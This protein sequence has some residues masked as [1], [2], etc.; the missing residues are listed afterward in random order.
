LGVLY[1][2]AAYLPID[3]G[4]PPARR[5]SLLER[6]GASLAL[7]QPWVELDGLAEVQRL[8]IDCDL[9]AD[10][11]APALEFVQ[12]PADLAY[13]IY[14]SG[15]TGE[16]KGVMLDHRGPVNYLLDINAH[17]DVRSTDRA[18][19]LSSLSF[20]LS[21]YD[22][23]GM[24]AAG[25]AVVLPEAG[26]ARDPAF[27]AQYL[28][29]GVTVWNSVPA[30]LGLLVD[31]AEKRPGV[32]EAMGSVQK[33]MLS[34]DW[35][36]V[37]LP[38]AFRS[39]VSNSTVISVGGATETS[40]NAV[41][42][43]IG[44][45]EPDWPSIP[46]GKP[47][48]NQTAW[49]LSPSLEPCPTYVAGEIH[50]GGVGLAQG[51]W[52]DEEQ[53][54]QRF[55]L[56]PR[57]GERLYRTGDWGR[58]LPSG[59]IEFLGRRDQQVKVHGYRVELGE[60]EAAL[61]RNAD[62][63]QAV[64]VA[65]GEREKRLVAHVVLGASEEGF[66]AEPGRAQ[67]RELA[68]VRDPAAR[69][70]LVE[71]MLSTPPARQ[72]EDVPV[73]VLPKEQAAPI[74]T[75][76]KHRVADAAFDVA[77]L[78]RML[79]PLR[80]V[81]NDY[82]PLPKARYASPGSLYSVQVLVCVTPD[83]ID[84]LAG[85]VY[86]H[87][88]IEHALVRVSDGMALVPERASGQEDLLK[89]SAFT[90][91]LIGHLAAIAPLYGRLSEPFC[92]LEA[93][94]MSHLLERAATEE[95]V[96]LQSLVGLQLDGLAPVLGLAPGDVCLHALVGGTERA[97]RGEGWSVVLAAAERTQPGADLSEFVPLQSAVERMQFKVDHRSIRHIAAP[98]IALP[99]G[100]SDEELEQQ[101]VSRR[102]FR[103]YLP[104]AV[105][106]QSLAGLLD[107][108][109]RMHKGSRNGAAVSGQLYP[110]HLY[111]SV[112]AGRV[113]GLESGAYRYDPVTHALIQVGGPVSIET[114]RVPPANREM[115]EAAA[116]VLLVV[117]QM[118]RIA[119]LCGSQSELVCRLEAGRLCQSLEDEASIHGLGLCQASFNFRGLEAAFDLS[120]SEMYVHAL[121][122]G[123][124]DWS[125]KQRGWP[126][127]AEAL[128]APSH[129]TDAGALRAYCEKVLP[130]YMVPVQIQI[131]ESLPLNANGKVD[132]AALSKQAWHVPATASTPAAPLGGKSTQSIIELTEIVSR[133]AAETFAV[134]E[135]PIETPFVNLGADSLLA[136]RFRN[137]LGR[138]L[139]RSLPAT[140]VY[141]YPS[142]QAIV[143]ALAPPIEVA[144]PPIR[145]DVTEPIAIVGMSCRAPGGVVDL[146]SYWALLKE[147]R[148][149]IGPFPERWDVNALFDPDPEAAGKS[150]TREGG[151]LQDVDQ[152]DA[153]FF[154][155]SPREAIAMD[156]QQRLVLEVVW[157]ALE[158]AGLRPDA[159][160]ESMT[161]VYL[162]SMGSDYGQLNASLEAMDGHVATGQASSVL[163]GRVSYVLG[164][165]GP[166]MT[167]DTACSSSLV[168]L[169][170][171]CSGLRQGECDLA[172]AGG[173]QV[174]STPSFFVEF[175]RLRGL[176]PD[177]RCKSF[178]A[179]ADGVGWSEGC[180]VLVLKRLSDAKRDGDRVLAVLRGS[181]VNQDGRS[182]GLT[183]PNGPS[184]QRVIRRALSV[185]GLAAS[186]ID[187]VEAHGTGT[188]LGDPIEA[189][190]LAAVFG[191]TRQK[192]KPL[193]IGSSKSNLGHTSAAAGV[194]G[195]M[196]MVLAL[197]HERLPK[198]LHAE[199]PSAHIAWEGSGLSLLQEPRLWPRRAERPRIFGVSA[200]GVS[201]TNAHVVVEEAPVEA[202]IA[203]APAADAAEAAAAASSLPPL[204]AWPVLLSARS[205]AALK[206]QAERLREHV[207]AHPDL[208]LVD[209]AYS[210]AT[211]RTAFEHRAA[212]VADSR[213]GLLSAL[214]A[215]AQGRPAPQTA[216][217]RARGEGKVVF[218]FPGQGSQWQGM[219][220]SLLDTS[221]VFRARLEACE[222]AL[223][224]H[225]NWSL[226]SV[227][228]SEDESLL[229]RID[230]VQ[231]V[232]FAVMVALAAVWR[233][234][235]IS[236]DAVVGHSQGEVAAAVVAGALSLEDGAKIVAL[237]SQALKRLAGK[238]GMIAVELG[239]EALREHL[240]KWG[241]RLSIAAINSPHATLVSGDAEVLD[242]FAA[243]LMAAE[244]FARKVRVD[245]ASHCAQVEAVRD[246]LLD[247]LAGL[248]PRAAELPLY[249]TVTGAI[250]DGSELD[251]D[252][253][254]R[255]L[256]QIV[257]FGEAAE[258]LLADG[259]RFFVE[260]SPHPVLTLALQE[261]LE[262]AQGVVV[263]SLR[264]GEGSHS[265]LLL[266][267][268]ELYSR[269]LAF[270]WPSFFAPHAPRRVA[271]PTYAFQ[272]ERFWLE[273]RRQRADS[274]TVV[275]YDDKFWAAVESEDLDVLGG[276]LQV[277]DHMDQ[278]A[279]VTLLPKLSN[280][281]RKQHAL[282]TIDRWRYRIQWQPLSGT[283]SRADLAGTWLL[284]VPPATV[285]QEL[286]L[287]LGSSLTDLGG[288]VSVIA[289]GEPETD[290]SYLAQR[291]R[292]SLGEAPSLRGILS[293]VALDEQPLPGF[294]PVPAGLALTL[295]L[296][297]ALG[298]L[299][300]EVPV[301]S[302][303]RGA[304]S[305]GRSDR[306]ESPVQAL[307]W[308]FG[309][310]A[311]L[312]MPQRWGGL[313]DLPIQ[314]DKRALERIMAA[315]ANDSGEDQLAVRS[316]GIFA[317]RLV[318]A[319]T[320]DSIAERNYKPNGTILIT[321]GTGAIGGHVARWL[322]H[323][324]AEH[325]VL[326]SRQ[327]AGAPAAG[328]LSTELTALG[329]RVTLAACD[330]ADRQA[331]A[332]LLE[333]L[334][335]QNSL[336]RSVFHAGGIGQLLPLAS[337]TPADLAAV[338]SAKVTGAQN[339]HE[340]LRGHS[341]DAF[342]LFSSGAGVWGSA[343][344]AGYASGNAFLDALAEQRHADGLTATSIA[345]GL[346]ADG[347]MGDTTEGVKYFTRRGMLPMPSPIAIRALEWSLDHNETTVA[348]ANI[349]WNRFA[350]SYTAARRR[351]LLDGIAEARD[352][353]TQSETLAPAGEVSERLAY[354]NQLSTD[355]EKE[356]ALLELVR[357]EV[358]TVLALT[359][360]SQL[361]I[362]RPLQEIGL[363][364]LMAVEIRNRLA[365]AIGQRLPATL[366]FNHP[367]SQAMAAALVTALKN[368]RFIIPVQDASAGDQDGPLVHLIRQ[369]EQVGAYKDGQDILSLATRIRIQSQLSL[370]KTITTTVKEPSSFQL[371][372]G[373]S[374][375]VL[376]CIPPFLPPSGPFVYARFV[377]NLNKRRDIWVISHPGY[378]ESQ[379]LT[380]HLG[381]LI[382]S[383]AQS[384]LQCAG[385]T[386]FVL[387]GHSAGAWIA[388]MVAAHAEKIGHRAAGVAL[389][390]PFDE[391]QV[392][393]SA[394]LELQSISLKEASL[395]GGI[396]DATLTASCWYHQLGSAEMRDELSMA[397]TS[398]PILH[399][400][401]SEEMV[402]MKEAETSSILW[403]ISKDVT[404]VP[405][406]HFSMLYNPETANV[407]DNW[408]SSLT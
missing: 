144:T 198:T 225:V 314:L 86:Y 66:F 312:D 402:H 377:S 339:L 124:A 208:A 363:D 210:L 115:F 136:L 224:P 20:D 290:R 206:G 348:V 193:Y 19:G 135:V 287:R 148:D 235:G 99:R 292:E 46:W 211:T 331:F 102:S 37:S 313:L 288:E 403:D 39:Q 273:A 15:S 171:A 398:A 140:L 359:S 230:V 353:L 375:P 250:V 24:F 164:L 8:V 354:L 362:D 291:L 108:L 133:V 119:P 306:L 184:Q 272:R 217:G 351:P 11:E 179:A 100:R 12:T 263:G 270:D 41:L 178:S 159:L 25:G 17:L 269:G 356:Q 118:E 369:A 396:S 325:I 334:E 366:V 187:A 265:R 52:R 160:N 259:F 223:A 93:G 394:F 109:R 188:T 176:A 298:D 274:P 283:F 54:Q 280:W 44:R 330:I 246:D 361:E 21:V 335:A 214:E 320:S 384:A 155:I 221:P 152:F 261:T 98:S 61:E 249:S 309:Y 64:V 132:R 376:I 275:R 316:T 31:H 105:P 63:Q 194:L 110:L 181:A 128:P 90:L 149:V 399:V 53:T 388:Y 10:N 87:H 372:R 72:Q 51:Y 226:L 49:I 345:W 200:F 281:R 360:P 333:E 5:R 400:R 374:S 80:R 301:W 286:A 173:V 6:S 241:E 60:I 389:L 233:A 321:G 78:A 405:G 107:T 116:F 7:I 307:L 264:R 62:V 303:S 216:L 42:Y 238:G 183:A 158:R 370:P 252:Y 332:S 346:W 74:C 404:Y 218:V 96:Q 130:A 106:L 30:L 253:W 254:Y 343:L 383:R 240:S 267:L 285:A 205:E 207:L 220:L 357:R 407:V 104:R 391:S 219:A 406:N 367:T 27:W 295:S 277:D 260:V 169:H 390:D 201:G 147:G 9:L 57:T 289:L 1:S 328:A 23:F 59:D 408:L 142:V 2:G 364:S 33:V 349:D 397:R 342:V 322:A 131:R 297:Q 311:G 324:G 293:L 209:L 222:A 154:G 199:T 47:M 16:P 38:D 141:D 121:V 248:S 294:A 191:P 266:S 69:R 161:G 190:A 392:T 50:V 76:P 174:M 192:E 70:A 82:A 13:I 237:R 4:L 195:V 368:A 126:F 203:L 262:P 113:A 129:A 299:D 373:P 151:F 73:V 101:W 385:D 381:D 75:P 94:E 352:A 323:Q 143:R 337:S 95:G 344:Q 83:R 22:M 165:Q 304:V 305:V 172:L 302:L 114:K 32:L 296:F 167:V 228:H 111:V 34:G 234:I 150:Y 379:T 236:P 386:P 326:V 189:G 67:W 85:G 92:A 177:G 310:V 120:S 365:A 355:E 229:D 89:S 308:G 71:T 180:G 242:A 251:A 204:P 137:R 215:L 231:P 91:L 134:K 395:L 319:A 103:A 202:A 88:P 318:R 68:L 81:P 276:A 139:N 271:L 125:G 55:I 162:G 36:P 14:T 146:E 315:L 255:N 279:L 232:L 401:A 227:L 138:V 112:K 175:S 26:E 212:I 257:R 40:I 185:S 122:G 243:D 123:V 284:L 382:A 166:A 48:A 393:S 378:E 196:K 170:L 168:A 336:P 127:L 341:L 145:I 197:Q 256:R 65:V 28:R 43:H 282:G 327:G 371:T 340:L 182:Q 278:Q 156:P 163:S 258:G 153:G 45:V 117:G 29:Q 35:I 3:A 347:G 157:E 79:E 268:A 300:I 247:N 239:V 18:F 58:W 213:E 329:A 387:L 97:V 244:I 56:H 84:G 186:D 245:Y 350:P 77:S 380:T 338:L 317:R 358:A